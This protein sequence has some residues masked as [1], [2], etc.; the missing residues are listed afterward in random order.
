MLTR[1]L[2]HI[3][4]TQGL[5]ATLWHVFAKLPHKDNIEKDR[6]GKTDQD[7]ADILHLPDQSLRCQC[8]LHQ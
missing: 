3:G 7:K 4:L 6:T 1:P 8:S 5:C 2:R